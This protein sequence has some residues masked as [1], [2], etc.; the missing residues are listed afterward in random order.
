MYAGNNPVSFVD[1]WGLEYIVVS[2]SE[3]DGSLFNPRYKY[4]FVEPAIKKIKELKELNDGQWI[5]WIVSSTGY[6][7]EDLQNMNNIAYDIGVGI[8]FIDSAAELQN[9]IN[10]QD[11]QVWNLSENRINDPIK[12]F[13]VFSHGVIGSV[14]LGYK[15][16]NDSQL[17][18]DYNWIQGIFPEAFDSP[19]SAFY[20]CRTGNDEPGGFSFAQYWVNLTGGRTW[21]SVGR[22][23]YNPIT[24]DRTEEEERISRIYGFNAYGSHYYPTSGDNAYWKNF[25][26]MW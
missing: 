9:Y 20:S 22:T 2:A 12:K 14:E 13:V 15:Q 7:D 25:Y 21:A 8:Q 11:T 18:L 3:Y 5:T 1:P 4:N 24:A 26:K 17:R 10:S 23:S 6:S 16:D 19:N